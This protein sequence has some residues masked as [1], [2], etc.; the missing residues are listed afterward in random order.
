MLACSGHAASGIRSPALRYPPSGLSGCTIARC[1]D[2]SALVIATITCEP[3]GTF[4]PRLSRIVSAAFQ[5]SATFIS[6]T[7]PTVESSSSTGALLTSPAA[8]GT[9]ALMV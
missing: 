1:D 4:T 9:R 8:D 6:P 3:R 2:P 7:L 5:S